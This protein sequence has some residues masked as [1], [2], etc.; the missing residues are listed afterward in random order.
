MLQFRLAKVRY[1]E[2]IAA[3]AILF[4]EYAEWLGIDLSFQGFEAELESL[5]GK[6][7][8]PDGDLL[9]AVAPSG[10]AL[11][12]VGVRPI[13]GIAVC[14]MKRLY[15]RPAARHLGLGETLVSSIIRSAEELGYAEMKLDTLPAMPEAH[16]LYRRFGFAEIP[17]YYP[18]PLPG[19]VYLGKPLS[20]RQAAAARRARAKYVG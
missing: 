15:V 14:E 11:G 10:E 3:T 17:P 1:A 19:T 6:Y 16:A 9:L 20:P 8:P 18:S 2:G 5:P 4:R 12:C 13:E 7:G